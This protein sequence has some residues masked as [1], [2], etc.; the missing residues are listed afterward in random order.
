[1]RW[2]Q[3][4]WQYNPESKLREA[5][6]EI[7]EKEFGKEIELK[8]IHAGL[9]CGVL[10]EKIPGVD[11]I[12][13]GPNIRGAHTPEENVSISSIQNV[14]KFFVKGVESLKNYY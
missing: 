7:Y 4:A 11:I 13:F 10:S 5:F 2:Q 12:S 6:C 1:M 8:A 14:W 3:P 9:E